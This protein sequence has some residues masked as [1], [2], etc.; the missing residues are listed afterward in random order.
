MKS[1]LDLCFRS[2]VLKNEIRECR[3]QW[4]GAAPLAAALHLRERLAGRKVGLVCSGGNSSLVHLRQAL[5]EG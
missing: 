3:L 5:K 2:I 1:R 4:A